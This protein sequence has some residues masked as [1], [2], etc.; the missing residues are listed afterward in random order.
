MQRAAISSR[1]AVIGVDLLIGVKP[2]YIGIP[3][4][5]E[6]FSST[7]LLYIIQMEEDLVLVKSA[8]SYGNQD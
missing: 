2:G 4:L 5:Y 3:T 7:V 8:A 6:G 1:P